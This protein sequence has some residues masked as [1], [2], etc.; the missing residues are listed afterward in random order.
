MRT[1]RVTASRYKMACHTD[2]ANPSQSLIMQ[3]CYPE[4]LKFSTEATEWGKKQEAIA[5]ESYITK[6]RQEHDEFSV[7]D[8]GLFVCM[9]HAFIGATPDGLVHCKCCGDGV[10]EIKVWTY[11][12]FFTYFKGY[13]ATT[14]Y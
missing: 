7:K 9:Q 6:V 1:G 8:S 14:I 13:A 2:P 12:F 11:Y 5:R 3:I 4:T 10:C